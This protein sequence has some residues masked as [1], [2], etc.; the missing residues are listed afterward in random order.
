MILISKGSSDGYIANDISVDVFM[1]DCHNGNIF[2]DVPS[3]YYGSIE[4]KGRELFE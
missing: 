4:C 1:T 3:H 2:K